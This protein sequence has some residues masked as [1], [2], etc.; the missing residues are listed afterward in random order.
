MTTPLSVVGG[1][2]IIKY[3]ISFSYCKG[4]REESLGSKM[5]KKLSQAFYLGMSYL[6]LLFSDQLLF[7][8][9]K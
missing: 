1:E 9:I 5:N 3:M 7:G 2:G 8:I 6:V 4:Q